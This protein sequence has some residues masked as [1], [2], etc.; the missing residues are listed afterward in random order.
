M[1]SP[2]VPTVA[3]IKTSLSDG[4]L[5]EDIVELT[6]WQ[7]VLLSGL[8][9]FN[10]GTITNPLIIKGTGSA[11]LTVRNGSSNV[12][13]FVVDDSGNVNISGLISG[14]SGGRPI[15]GSA[16]GN[17]VA[18]QGQFGNAFLVN[19]GSNNWT[20]DR[21]SATGYGS[22]NINSGGGQPQVLTSASATLLTLSSDGGTGYTDLKLRSVYTTAAAFFARS[23][24]A[25]TDGHGV[26]AGTI[27]NAPS[28]GNPTKW[29]GVDDN[30]T[31]RYIPAW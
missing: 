3:G 5:P 23:A 9:S 22:F 18:L 11:L 6:R 7:V 28:A 26:S 24:V 1:S 21:L 19:G 30:G 15:I 13:K 8:T 16:T 25:L 12:D 31:T 17:G 27:T 4:I 2:A 29:I 20:F 10:G 14:A